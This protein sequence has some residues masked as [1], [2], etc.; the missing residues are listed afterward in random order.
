MCLMYAAI[1]AKISTCSRKR[2]EYAMRKD[3]SN[4]NI[5]ESIEDN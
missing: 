4:R 1:Y 2:Q 5:D 3:V